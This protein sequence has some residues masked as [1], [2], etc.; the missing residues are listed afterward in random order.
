[1]RRNLEEIMWDEQTYDGEYVWTTDYR[2]YF[3]LINMADYI[4]TVVN[5]RE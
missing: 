3:F 4:L 5:E 2:M 1:M